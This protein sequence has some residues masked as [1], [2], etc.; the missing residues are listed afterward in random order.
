MNI[1]KA[2]SEIDD[3]L[4]NSGESVDE[5]S[6]ERMAEIV[7]ADYPEA[8]SIDDID[9]DDFTSFMEEWGGKVANEVGKPIDLET[10]DRDYND[11]DW[12]SKWSKGCEN[13]EQGERRFRIDFANCN[14]YEVTD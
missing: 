8:A 2:K 7:A 5:W 4:I 11:H 13:V 1:T 14:V 3:Y 12:W 9:P 6:V 10:L